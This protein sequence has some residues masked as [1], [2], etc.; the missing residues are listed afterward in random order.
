MFLVILF[1]F[2]NKSICFEDEENYKKDLSNFSLKRNREY[3]TDDYC[4]INESK[5]I[6]YIMQ[7]IVEYFS[8]S[9]SSTNAQCLIL[10]EQFH[11]YTKNFF[12]LDKTNKVGAQTLKCSQCNKKFRGANLLNLHY[13]LFHLNNTENDICPGDFCQSMNCEKYKKY[14]GVKFI[15]NSKDLIMYNRQPIEKKQICNKELIPF[16][17]DTCMKL[18]EGCFEDDEDKISEYFDVFCNKI[19]CDISYRNQ[20]QKEGSFFDVIRIIFMYITGILTFIYLLI[21]WLTK[22]S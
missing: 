6:Y 4:N 11:K 14:Y 17:K 21:I 5:E 3:L 18:V 13:K 7:D 19:N 15:D 9:Q 12:E 8:L 16:Y 22:F 2:I 20:L 1:F 10:N